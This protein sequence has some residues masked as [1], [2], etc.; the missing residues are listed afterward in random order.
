MLLLSALARLNA[1]ARS[2]FFFARDFLSGH[3]PLVGAGL[4]AKAVCHPTFMST[5]TPSSRASPLPQFLCWF[6]VRDQ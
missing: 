4:L 3:T 6:S 1:L 5:D 2:G